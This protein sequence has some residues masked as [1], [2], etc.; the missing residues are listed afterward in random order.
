MRWLLGERAPPKKQR[1]WWSTHPLI[2]DLN[3]NIINCLNEK[4]STHSKLCCRERW[5]WQ[6]CE[7]VQESSWER[8]SCFP[9][10]WHST[11]PP[12]RTEP[13]TQHCRH[14]WARCLVC[15]LNMAP[16]TSAHLLLCEKQG[17]VRAAGVCT[18]HWQY[19]E[20]CCSWKR[21]LIMRWLDCC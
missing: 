14:Q 17:R 20:Q 5:V 21:W 7:Y 10:Q 8:W 11:H 1:S 13:R 12:P 9:D 6:I 2:L 19:A 4:S 3:M 15:V 16:G 18:Q